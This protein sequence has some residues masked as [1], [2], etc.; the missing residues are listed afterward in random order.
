MKAALS[1]VTLGLVA[2]G[3]AQQDGAVGRSTAALTA[4]EAVDVIA[5]D[6]RVA[7]DARLAQM[8]DAQ[9]ASLL[10]SL[11]WYDE[12]PFDLRARY[13]A[14]GQVEHLSSRFLAGAVHRPRCVDLGKPRRRGATGRSVRRVG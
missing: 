13:G 3:C 8:Q 11:A 6:L 12:S 10:N 1:L 5:A 9:R 7:V 14:R 4:Q 2:A